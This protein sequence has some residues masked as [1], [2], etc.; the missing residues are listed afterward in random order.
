M[1]KVLQQPVLDLEPDRL[2]T[3]YLGSNQLRLGLATLAYLLLEGVR[4]IG[5]AGTELAQATAGACD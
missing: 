2:S 1:E 4:A 5:C 3:H